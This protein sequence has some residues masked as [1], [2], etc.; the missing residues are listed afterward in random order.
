M[1][2]LE[3]ID[4]VYEQGATSVHALRAVDL[5]VETGESVAILGPS[6]SGKSTLLHVIGCLDTPSHGRYLL[7]GE[8]VS[9]LDRNRMAEVRNRGFGF[10]FQAFHLMPRSTALENVAMPLRFAGVPRAE[11]K[12]RALRMLERVGLADRVGHRPPELS[13]GQQQRVAVARALANHP[14]VILA[15]E[16]TGNLDSQSGAEIFELLLELNI[17][18][19]TVVIVTHDEGLAARTGRVIRMLDG[20]VVA[21][22]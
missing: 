19:Q 17:E 1:I 4:K 22:G 15:D 7:D 14:A 18:G 21:D 8:D 10:I 5:V 9:A 3:G 2:R 12:E 20:R 16:P 11:Q 6:G 13:G